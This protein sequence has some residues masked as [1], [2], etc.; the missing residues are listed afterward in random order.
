MQ[1][2]KQDIERLKFE[3][4]QAKQQGDYARVA[5]IQYE[6][7]PALERQNEQIRESLPNEGSLIKEE[8]GAEDIADVVSRWTG[9][10]V[11]KMMTSERDKLLSLEEELHH[12]VVGQDLA[13]E[14]VSNAIRRNRAGLSD[15]NRPIG[16]FL[17]LGQT[18]VGKTELAKALAEFLFD[19][20]RMVTRIDM[21]E[22]QEKFAVTRLFGA[23]PGYVGYEE[24]GQLTEAV[25]RKPYSVVLF[26]EIEKAHPDVFNTLLQVL[27]EGHMTDGKGRNVNFK[28]TIIIMTSNLRQEQLF[29]QEPILTAEGRPMQPIRREFLNRIDEIVNFQALTEQDIR[30]VV[31]IQLDR[32][33]R[34]LKDNDIELRITDD[35]RRY[36]AREGYDPEF[37]ARPV[38]RAIQHHVLNALSKTLLSGRVDRTKPIVVDYAEGGLKFSN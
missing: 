34:L 30:R 33:H 21:S 36:L 35:A 13:I 3:A 37:G 5:K 24:G 19:D 11:S 10:P 23:P 25:R 1:K 17:F 2:N 27:D 20:E 16:S 8:I 15:P 14:A 12:R 38:K 29:G 32:C 7:I 28:N 4:E 6:T 31:D 18:G 26:D 22:Y 9:I